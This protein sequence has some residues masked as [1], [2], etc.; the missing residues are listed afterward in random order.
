MNPSDRTLIEKN[1]LF[2]GVGL[3]GVE[4]L[5]ESGVQRD[6]AAGEPLLQP[7]I[8]NRDLH[9]ILKG[10]LSVFLDGHGTQEYASLLAGECTGE[11]SFV[12]GKH[13]CA[14]VVA[15]EPSRILSIPHDVV[16]S[17]VGHS[18]EIARNLLEIIAGRMRGSNM[19]LVT[20]QNKELQFEHQ[21]CV[22]A[23]TGIYNRHWMGN[24]F[25][26]ALQRCEHDGKPYALMIADIDHFKRVNDTYGHLVGDLALKTVARCIS[27]NLRPH[28]LLVRFGGEEFAVLLPE[29]DEAEAIAVA[30]RLRTMVALAEIRYA[31]ISFCT[32]ISIG[33]RPACKKETLEGLINGADCALYRAKALGRNRVEITWQP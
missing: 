1:F 13:P 6:L 14:A 32:T 5:L 10:R 2:R 18:H 4:F 28:D 24:A 9:L 29:T 17:L 31:D 27:E 8:P 19:A 33:I 26:R 22:D 30:E 11:I 3:E 16:W 7:E 21:A 15:T 25:P 12:D 20:S 23:L